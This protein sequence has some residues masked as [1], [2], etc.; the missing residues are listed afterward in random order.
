M[1]L[2]GLVWEGE[3]CTG[4]KEPWRG[5]CTSTSPSK[6]AGASGTVAEARTAQQMEGICCGRH[7]KARSS[8]GLSSL[9]VFLSSCQC[10]G[11]QPRRKQS[12]ENRVGGS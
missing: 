1:G 4:G 5:F 9:C 12:S 8:A 11:H 7:Q 3:W 10:D 6:P 2:G